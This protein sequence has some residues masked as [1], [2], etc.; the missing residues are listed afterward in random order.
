VSGTYS[1]VVF[2]VG[3]VLFGYNPSAIVDQI[4][5][6]TPFKDDFLSHLF[7]S[8]SWQL[9]D[10]GDL[11]VDALVAQLTQAESIHNDAIASIPRLVNQFTDHL[12]PIHEMID[13]F[14]VIA[15]R[16]STY[17]LSN[18]QDKPFDRLREH[19]PF[20]DQAH[21]QVVSAKVNVMKP[22]P[23]IYKLL[24][25]TYQINPQETVFIDD[26]PDNIEAAR[27]FGITGILYQN[28]TQ[29]RQELVALGIQL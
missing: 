7:L 25:D 5:G 23:A 4:L 6:E 3:N 2:D 18:F 27:Q 15:A 22:E 16:Y 13:L 12:D 28:P 29:V 14:Q 10:R 11:T 24:L 19:N 21:G 8:P 1:T 9:M 20:L 26:L 17:I